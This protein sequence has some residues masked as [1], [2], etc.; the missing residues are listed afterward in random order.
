MLGPGNSQQLSEVPRRIWAMSPA[1]FGRCGGSAGTHARL[2]DRALCCFGLG[3]E[4]NRIVEHGNGCVHARPGFNSPA[5][6]KRFAW[7]P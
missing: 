4:L 3:P 6:F 7:Q 5:D 1:T 2:R